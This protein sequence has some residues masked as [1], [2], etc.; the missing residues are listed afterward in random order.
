MRTLVFFIV[1][2]LSLGGIALANEQKG[3]KRRPLVECEQKLCI[4]SP[5]VGITSENRPPRIF[6]ENLREFHRFYEKGLRESFSTSNGPENLWWVMALLRPRCGKEEWCIE[7][8]IA[9]EKKGTK[10]ILVVRIFLSEEK[11]FNAES[12]AKRAAEKTKMVILSAK[13]AFLKA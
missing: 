6:I 13:L 9:E 5:V 7:V 2:F 1:T 11:D 10:R 3:E 8:N 12:E 4:F